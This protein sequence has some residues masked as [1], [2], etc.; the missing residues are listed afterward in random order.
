MRGSILSK[1]WLLMGE[2]DTESFLTTGERPAKVDRGVCD[3]KR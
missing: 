2:V 3:E 1:Q